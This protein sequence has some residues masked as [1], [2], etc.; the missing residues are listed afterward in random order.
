MLEKLSQSLPRFSGWIIAAIALLVV[1]LFI[2]PQQL[3][4]VAYKLALISVAAVVGYWLD[5]SLFPYARP[6]SY[7]KKHWHLGTDEPE[8]LAD[9]EVVGGYYQIFAVAMLRRALVILAV[10]IGVALGL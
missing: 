10:V 3:D 4:V 1:L 8:G 9:F 2:S 6:D 5:R 7:L